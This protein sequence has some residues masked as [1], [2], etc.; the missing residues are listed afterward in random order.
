MDNDIY[1][2]VEHLRG[3]VADISYVMAAAAHQLADGIGGRVVAILLGHHSEALITDLGV[4]FVL[5][6]DHESLAEF[7]SDA[8][9]SVLAQILKENTPR[10][11]LFGDTSIG[12]DVAGGISVGLGLPLVSG[13]RSFLVTDGKPKYISQ[14]YGGKILAEGELPGPTGIVTMIPGAYKPDLGKA[15]QPPEVRTIS[16]HELGELRVHFKRYIEPEIADV[17]ISREPILIAV[18][19]GIQ[20]EDNLELAYELAEACGGVVCASRPV[21][22]Q[23][24]I[25]TGRMVGKS[26][27]TVKPSLYLAFGISG[28]PEHS[29][30]MSDSELIVAV[31]TDP[32][33]PIFDIA[34]YGAEIDLLDLLPVL[35]EK[36]QEAKA[37]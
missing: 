37:G 23:G 10:V 31:N 8:Y 14:I 25:P 32:T 35:T 2:L 17:D 33:A 4:D 6:V 7:S 27:K 24:W 11:M 26:G 34:Q 16:A 5:Y 30:G 28:A 13:C 19:R 15:S 29:E 21:V 20:R 9:Y 18:G 22:D 1:L 3:Q 36:V 12:A